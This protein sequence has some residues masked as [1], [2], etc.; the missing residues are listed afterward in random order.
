MK[1]RVDVPCP[2]APH[3]AEKLPISPDA[4]QWRDRSKLYI[5]EA[6]E[7]IQEESISARLLF[8]CMC[9]K[10]CREMT[11]PCITP[12]T[13][14]HV[15]FTPTLTTTMTTILVI[16][17]EPQIR[18]NIVEILELADYQALEAS[19]GEEGVKQA[20]THSPDLILCD[21]MMPR[22][23]GYDVLATLRQNH[24]TDTVPFIFL[25][26]RAERGDQRHGMELGADDY[27][28]KPFTPEELLHAIESRLAQQETV[29]RH[30]QE[31]V[32]VLT[33]TLAL[34]LPHELNTPLNGIMGL[35]SLLSEC[36]DELSTNEIAEMARDIH[37]SGQ[38]LHRLTQNFLLYSHL[39]LR[40]MQ[41]QMMSPL[42]RDV[43][44][45]LTSDVILNIV[46]TIGHKTNRF[47]DIKVELENVV[48]AIADTDLT[49]MVSELLD[50]AVKFSP[51]DT[52]ITL[53]SYQRQDDWVL[54]VSDRGRGF[55][56]EQAHQ[57]GAGMQFERSVYEQQGSGLGLAIAQRFAQLYHG[58]LRITSLHGPTT[59]TVTLPLT[60]PAS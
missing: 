28:T 42:E 24:Y 29:Q 33:R 49:K 40:L 50:N 6:V 2:C 1:I 16:E 32:E 41:A 30:E 5:S 34:A 22:M 21:V 36:A 7:E 15:D 38:R 8:Q 55:T 56:H 23:D 58:K 9:F 19:D 53:H 51:A 31:H 12:P 14:S 46:E 45:T 25:T 3:G 54:E 57:I 47:E 13:N 17:D 39:E 48:V 20:L 18:A 27:L 35:A 52:P 37:R 4:K 43:S 60:A 10:V 26:A 11:A 59:L 44:T